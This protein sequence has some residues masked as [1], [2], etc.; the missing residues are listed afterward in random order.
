MMLFGGMSALV[1]TCRR[2]DR[3]MSRHVGCVSAKGAKC[4]DMSQTFRQ[5]DLRQMSQRM[6]RHPRP[7]QLGPYLGHQ[8]YLRG[9]ELLP[10]PGGQSCRGVQVPHTRSSCPDL[11]AVGGLP[12]IRR[13]VVQNDSD[14]RGLSCVPKTAAQRRPAL[15]RLPC[16]H[17]PNRCIKKIPTVKSGF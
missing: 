1:L 8:V 4:H 7:G 2:V 13:G 14:I 16:S 11:R 5:P 6:S 3:Q 17:A 12:G 9:G 15:L 10:S